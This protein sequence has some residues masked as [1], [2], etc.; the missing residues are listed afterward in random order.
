VD[1]NYNGTFFETQEMPHL[2]LLRREEFIPVR[3]VRDKE[4]GDG[5][6]SYCDSAFDD[7]LL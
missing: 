2:G 4:K 6:K 5:T 1:I 7:L 3:K